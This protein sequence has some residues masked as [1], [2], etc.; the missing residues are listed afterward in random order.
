MEKGKITMMIMV[1]LSHS[2]TTCKERKK[3]NKE[4]KKQ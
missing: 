4:N 3:L 1:I 2:Y